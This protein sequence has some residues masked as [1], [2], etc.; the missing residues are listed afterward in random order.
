ML[1]LLVSGQSSRLQ[2]KYFII[3]MSKGCNKIKKKTTSYQWNFHVLLNLFMWNN[4]SIQ[5][6]YCSTIF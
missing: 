4:Y 5:S 6:E 1:N 3:C 2:I